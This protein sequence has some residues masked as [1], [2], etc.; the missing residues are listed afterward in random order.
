MRILL[1]TTEY[2]PA[3]GG[4][5]TVA[6]EE[7]RGLAALGDEIFVEATAHPGDPAQ[8]AERVTVRYTEVKSRA[9]LRLAPLT[10]H[11][12]RATAHLR[13]DFI[14]S[15]TYRGYGLP[16]LL[17]GGLRHIPYGIFFHGTEINT[18]TR[19]KA[20]RAILETV[21]RRAAF[22]ATNSENTRRILLGHFPRMKTPVVAIR[23]GVQIERFG[24]Q[25]TRAKGLEL[26]REWLAQLPAAQEQCLIML[27][28][29]RM[30]RQKGIDY[31]IRAL[32]EI[33]ARD[34]DFPAV[35]VAAGI[36]PDLDHFKSLAAELSLQGRV[37][38]PGNIPY[39]RVPEA[40][41]ASDMY[42][43]PSQPVGD[44]LESFGISF[45]EAQASGLPCIGS[46]WGGV[47]EAVNPGKSAILVPTGDLR[48]VA[49]A[50][51]RLTEET[52]LRSRMA[53]AGR[54]HAAEYSWDAH[55][56]LL[57]TRIHQAVAAG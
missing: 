32:A 40:F 49:D 5:S 17:A 15:P 48:A 11:L 50:M 27:S 6:L 25:A 55:C 9:V 33:V 35:Y 22:V 7:A 20:R 13:P 29:C 3:P 16:V 47:P 31:A 44:F 24:T 45:V 14:Y 42:I 52:D 28:L 2:P 30:N 43:Q 8:S 21:I 1:A 18:D 37:L 10:L 12:W 4:V 46:D 34:P 26:R 41:A 23:P 38:F 39:D 53:E 54:R 57:R 51:V 36:G 56:Q 19:S